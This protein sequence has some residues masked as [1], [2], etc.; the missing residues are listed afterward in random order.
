MKK[1]IALAAIAAVGA[2]F[3]ACEEEPA[4]CVFAYSVS[5][6]GKTSVAKATKAPK[7]NCDDPSVCYRKSGSFKAKGYVY[8]KTE[9]AD[10]G[11][12]SDDTCGC[13][14]WTGE[15]AVSSY[16][17]NTKTLKAIEGF[18]FSSLARIGAAKSE[19]AKTVEVIGTLEGLT[20]AGFGRYDMKNS[21]IT[22]AS[23]YFAGTLAAPECETC[24]YDATACE[25]DCESVGSVAFEICSDSEVDSDGATVPA[26]GKW[27]IK[28]NKS[29]AKKLAKTGDELD[30]TVVVPSKVIAANAETND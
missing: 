10:G 27:T 13:N 30:V 24:T 3:G 7:S 1:L 23:G 12:C 14:E 6:S 26:Y 9:L 4:E 29:V 25:D 8:G 19:K 5:L 15:G 21:R 22:S 17:W 20:L 28:Y 16:I 18:E 11:E 2:T